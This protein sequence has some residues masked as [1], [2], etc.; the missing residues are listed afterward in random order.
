M[1]SPLS[2]ERHQIKLLTRKFNYRQITRF[3]SF[4]STEN[5]VK[6]IAILMGAI[7]IYAAYLSYIFRSFYTSFQL[8]SILL[9]QNR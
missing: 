7:F 8:Q 6:D 1:R 5:V 9:R 2:L 4:L 3:L